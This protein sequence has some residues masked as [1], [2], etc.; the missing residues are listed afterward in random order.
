MIKVKKNSTFVPRQNCQKSDKLKSLWL[1]RCLKV[2]KQ[3]QTYNS[4]VLFISFL[5]LF[6]GP[7]SGKLFQVERL[8]E[9]ESCSDSFLTWGK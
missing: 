2:L 1:K 6:L 7:W 4:A 8:N 5:R 3:V 9:L